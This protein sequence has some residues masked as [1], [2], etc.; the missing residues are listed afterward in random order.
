MRQHLVLLPGLLCDAALW[1]RALPVLRDSVQG[2]SVTIPPLDSHATIQELACALLRGSPAGR[3]AVAGCSFGGYVAAEMLRQG[4]HERISHIALIGS[5]AR[6]DTAAVRE[7][8]EQQIIR[9]RREGLSGILAEQLP[10]LVHPRHLPADLSAFWEAHSWPAS[11]AA[12]AGE[13]RRTLDSSDASALSLS[14]AAE[15]AAMARRTSVESFERQQRC[16]LTRL[17]A[18]ATLRDAAAA[19]VH[20]ALVA[21]AADALIPLAAA[22]QLH[23]SI[24]TREPKRGT[25]APAGIVTLE[26]LPGCGHLSPL[27]QPDGVAAAIARL[28]QN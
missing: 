5:Q 4:G 21:G 19:G 9:A 6:C 12:H 14:V 23:E 11:R 24:F 15:I 2:L 27:E 1:R 8:R 3:I 18:T 17:D 28:L 25:T 16:I 10:L 13:D 22:K 7:R 26:V 20:V